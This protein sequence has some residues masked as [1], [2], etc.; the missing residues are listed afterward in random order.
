MTK[1]GR[2]SGGESGGKSW[3]LITCEHGGNQVPARYAPLFRGWRRTLKTHRGFDAG[4]LQMA[5]Q[6]AAALGAPL[7]ASQ[8]TRLLVDLNRSIGHPTLRSDASRRAPPA[9]Q[10][11][12]LADHY[13][14][15]RTE[16]ERLVAEAIARGRRVI[17]VGSHSFT[18]RLDGQLRTADVGLLYDPARPGE[19][20]LADRWKRALEAAAPALRVRRNYPYLGKHDGLTAHLRRLHPPAAY[21]GIELEINQALVKGPGRPWSRLRRVVIESLQSTLATRATLASE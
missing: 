12:M 13:L 3:L 2:K 4:A 17:H 7:V 1:K 11:R 8:V 16:V 14:P 20:R 6:M 21:V 5:R 9:E 10:Q 18:P 19:R 15:H